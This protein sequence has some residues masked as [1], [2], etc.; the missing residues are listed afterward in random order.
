MIKEMGEVPFFMNMHPMTTMLLEEE[1]AISSCVNIT[2]QCC[3]NL[4]SWLLE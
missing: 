1:L 4:S 2:E 3:V